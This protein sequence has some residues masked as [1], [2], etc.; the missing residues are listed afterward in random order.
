[1]MTERSNSAAI[2][3]EARATDKRTAYC[4]QQAA[5]CA[6]AAT[7]AILSDVRQAYL[8]IEQAWLQLAPDIHGSRAALGRLREP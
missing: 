3:N 2:S 5:E 6:S 7:I 8:N 1:M 4:R